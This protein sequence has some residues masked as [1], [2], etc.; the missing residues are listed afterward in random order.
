MSKW[1]VVNSKNKKREQ[2]MSTNEKEADRERGYDE[3]GR[4]SG[5]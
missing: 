5:R 4:D 1:I 3:K 2:R